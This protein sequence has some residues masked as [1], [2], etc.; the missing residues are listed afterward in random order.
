MK[1]DGKLPF[2]N[3]ISYLTSEIALKIDGEKKVNDIL[4]IDS[5]GRMCIVELKSKRHNKVKKQA[6]DFENV[7]NT[8]KAFFINLLKAISTIGWNGEIRKIAVWPRP[9]GTTK[10]KEYREVEEINYFYDEVKNEYK[11]E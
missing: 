2:C 11:F 1:N 9:K 3:N 7:V 8:E 5:E 4:A 10:E 6:I